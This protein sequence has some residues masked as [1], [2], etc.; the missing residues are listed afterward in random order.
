[1]ADKSYSSK[2]VRVIHRRSTW[3]LV[4]LF[5]IITFFQYAESLSLPAILTHFN[6]NLGL[7]R[8]SLER[9]LYLLPIIW[10]G[11]LF[12]WKGAAITSV[13]SVAAM[14]P[15][16][17]FI[18]PNPEDAIVE[19]IAVFV[20]GNTVAFS[21][22]SLQREK[23]RRSQLEM[24]QQELQ[25]QLQVIQEN[26]KRL[27]ALNQ[28][29]TIISQTLEL[30]DVLNSAI[31]CIMDVMGFEVILIY[32]LDE[33]KRELKMAAYWG[34]TEEFIRD[35]SE[36]KVDDGLNGK[37]VQ[38]GEPL[39]VHDTS[40][41]PEP[42][43]KVFIEE[44]ICSQ[45]IVPMIAKGKVV[46]TICTA[47]RSY[48]QFSPWEMELLTTIANQIGVSVDNAR[49]YQQQREM[50]EQLRSSEE[51]YRSLFENA[52]DAIWL[53]DL[54]G[55]I[56]AANDAYVRL[57]GYSLYELNNLKAAQV[58][59]TDNLAT[60]KNLEEYLLNLQTNKP[61]REIKLTKK[62]G[63][64][65]IIQ[66]SSSMMYGNGQ[67]VV[68]QHIARDVT[69]EKR[70]QENL[71]FFVQQITKAQEE[72]RKRIAQELH[73][74]TVQAMLVH[75]REIDDLATTVVKLTNDKIFARLQELYKQT[76]TIINGVRRLSQDLRPAVL[77]RLGLIPAVEWIADSTT[78]YS[79]IDI[80]VR[81]LGEERRLPDDVELVLFRIAQ[82]ALRNIWKHSKANKA[83]V[84]VEFEENIIRLS[85]QDNGQGF[86]LPNPIAD[87]PRYGML[88]LVGM[89]ERVRL[90]DGTIVFTSEDGE[91]TTVI[92][93]LPVPSPINRLK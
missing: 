18:S 7:T 74:D 57:T 49:L 29:S 43:R 4:I 16:G 28:T 19:S 51:R 1:M 52:H 80:N 65:A 48:H 22:E 31:N 54:E 21:L 67:P 73:D 84:I 25:S 33:D 75:A 56:I 9:I 37:V 13:I 72:E 79:G 5:A 8:Y 83:N 92:A 55:N 93:E 6:E 36:T 40:E 77:D 89:Q 12:G 41:I 68:I 63:S 14:L 2:L 11:A 46:G 60:A 53:N 70:M 59:S 34:I 47:M 81:F 39:L 35:V 23:K 91:G 15:R 76:N 69:E 61:I 32:I 42:T 90:L 20:I 78:E 71:Q 45:V 30:T 88:G 38:T 50:T 3:F 66:L 64:E 26:E 82:E 27:T 44:N 58:I 85:I 86:K 17:I 62:S 10:S 87:L 24:A